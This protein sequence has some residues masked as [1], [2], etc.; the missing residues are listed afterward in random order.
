MQIPEQYE[1]YGLA[2]DAAAHWLHCYSLNEIA[3]DRYTLKDM[4]CNRC[5]TPVVYRYHE[6]RL[7]TICCK[8]CQYTAQV[9][10]DNPREAAMHFASPIF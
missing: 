3:A 8:K 2:L 7:Y 1:K 6:S 10:A 5:G 9:E 4:L